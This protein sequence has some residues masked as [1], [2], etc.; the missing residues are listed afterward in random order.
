MQIERATERECP[1]HAPLQRQITK[2]LVVVDPTASEHPGVD[3]AARIAAGCGA[4]LELYVCDVVQEG[5][6][7]DR[8][9]REEQALGLL[10]RLAAGLRASGLEVE[11]RVEWHAPLEQGIGLRV[12]HAGA[13]F[14]VK[15]THRHQ[16]AATRGGY[17]L[18]DWTLIRQISVPLLLVRET[19]W[20]GHPRI[21]VGVDP[22]HPAQRPA[23]LDEALIAVGAEVANATRGVIDALHVLQEPPHL[24]G[25]TVPAA[26][27]AAAHARARQAVTRLIECSNSGGNPVELHFVTGRVAANVLGFAAARETDIL[28]LGSG[29]HSRWRQ[30]G[31]SGTAA[32]ILESL[33][34]DLLVVRPPGYVSPLLVTDDD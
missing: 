8:A 10:E 5:D 13:D 25:E 24:P 33:T 20:P 32:Q 2:M 18:T 21:T 7:A 12:L 6:P 9:T 34:C 15:E 4:A 30:S 14:V 31:A 28:V 26:T 16:L 19:P 3:K 17:G 27:R 29:A 22:M 11:C 23:T 1:L